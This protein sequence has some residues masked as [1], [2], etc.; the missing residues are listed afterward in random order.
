M[1][2]ETDRRTEIL[3]QLTDYLLEHGLGEASLR[4]LAAAAG[5]N[6]RMLVYHFRSKENLMVELVEEL[7][8]WHR[9]AFR[10]WLDDHSG[11]ATQDLLTY[12]WNWASSRKM[13]GLHRVVFQCASAGWQQPSVLGSPVR[14]LYGDWEQMLEASLVLRDVGAQDSKALA[15]AAIGAVRGLLL[16]YLATGDRTRANAGAHELAKWWKERLKPKRSR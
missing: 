1:A 5:T 15:A 6:A 9:E 13:E 11:T 14:R 12:L 7:R 2:S 8:L 3:R 4:P 10:R 16:D